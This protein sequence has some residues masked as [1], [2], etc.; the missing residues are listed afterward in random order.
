[1]D[2]RNRGHLRS[3]ICTAN[4][5]RVLWALFIVVLIGDL[6]WLDVSS[7]RGYSGWLAPQPILS[8]TALIF[9]LLVLS[10]QLE[11]QH[12]NTLEA[13]RHAAQDRLRLDIYQEIAQRIEASTAPVGHMGFIP[14]AFVGEL[15]VRK[16]LG[17][18]SQYR[19]SSFQEA[20]QKA[21]DSVIALMAVLEVY[22]IAMPE[23]RRFRTALAE[24]M[25][26]AGVTQG[27]FL[28]IAGQFIEPLRWPPSDPES[29][30]MSRLAGIIQGAAIEVQG[31]VWDLR[32]AAQNYLLGGLFPGQQA[33]DRTPGDPTVK[34]IRVPIRE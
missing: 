23:F 1:M 7:G 14:T 2:W 9:G 12:Q 20:S 26:R 10:L 31:I 33:P 32:V 21:S 17:S 30:E 3:R 11:K 8:V 27:D 4:T 34:V 5:A 19:F 29:E 6:I 25:R 13:N 24:S 16:Q 18:G 28:Q 15:V 22:E